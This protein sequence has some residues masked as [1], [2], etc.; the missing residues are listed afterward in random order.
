M[1]LQCVVYEPCAVPEG[2][3]VKFVRTRLNNRVPHPASLASDTLMWMPSLPSP[4]M[5]G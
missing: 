5:G 3:H 1:R 4:H 2:D